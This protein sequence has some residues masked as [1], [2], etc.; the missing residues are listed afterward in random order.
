MIA[1]IV[2][3][4]ITACSIFLEKSEA[5]PEYPIEKS[6]EKAPLW[7]ILSIYILFTCIVIVKMNSLFSLDDKGN[8]AS[9]A[10]Y[11]YFTG[12][13][14][15]ALLAWWLFSRKKLS[16]MLSFDIFLFAAIFQFVFYIASNS[17]LVSFD[18]IDMVFFG[19][20]DIIYIFL[21]VTAA[22]IIGTYPQAWVFRGFVFIFGF[23]LIGAFGLSELLYYE[24]SSYYY[25]IC[26]MTSLIMLAFII[27]LAP[28]LRNFYRKPDSSPA[29]MVAHKEIDRLTPR[30]NEIVNLYLNGYSNKQI[31]GMLKISP[32]TVKVHGRNIYE[33]LEIK[34]RIELFFHYGYGSKERVSNGFPK[35]PG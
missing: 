23:A 30:E 8:T 32:A 12:G 29:K 17:G 19:I 26:A 11:L 28:P 13:L 31:A 5:L 25:A 34:S 1:F 33:K 2:L 7:I 16:I 35:T 20:S 24:Y 14:I 21:F 18:G 22:A 6:A 10:Y 15:A 27:L 9:Y 3:A 4:C